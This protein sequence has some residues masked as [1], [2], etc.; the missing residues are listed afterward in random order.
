MAVTMLGDNGSP[1]Y[2][3]LTTDP[4]SG[5]RDYMVRL[6]AATD[7]Y[8]DGPYTVAAA[9]AGTYPIGTGW[10]IGNDNDPYARRL[11]GMRVRLFQHRE[12]ERHKHW[13]IEMRFSTRP[14]DRDHTTSVGNPLLEP[15][16]VSGSFMGEVTEATHD[17]DGNLVLSSSHQRI[18]GPEVEK[19]EDHPTIV[20]EQNVAQLNIALLSRISKTV[21]SVA[22]WGVGV[23]KIKLGPIT[24]QRRYTGTSFS[25]VFYSW[26]LEFQ[27]NWD[28]WR[29]LP[30]DEGTRALGYW[31]PSTEAWVT[32]GD[33]TNPSD[34][35]RY[36]DKSGEIDHVLLN[37]Q[38]TP[39]STEDYYIVTPHRS[40]ADWP[41]YSEWHTAFSNNGIVDNTD[42]DAGVKKYRQIDFAAELG[43]YIPNFSNLIT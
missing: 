39:I 30:P 34:F 26:R 10:V 6:R 7:D 41:T 20:V 22:L 17:K 24:W 25:S 19:E 21:N 42:S 32:D 28:T 33:A 9:A 40:G 5:H 13:S 23:E 31:D 2:W 8:D 35:K 38:G 37:G 43:P 4:A 27:L 15:P 16:K 11:P 12:G 29:G 14:V 36:R 18:H 1:T 3:E